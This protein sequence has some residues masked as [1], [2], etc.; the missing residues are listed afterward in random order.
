MTQSSPRV[1]IAAVSPQQ[2][3]PANVGRSTAVPERTAALAAGMCAGMPDH[4]FGAAALHW[5]RDTR[6]VPK[7]G[8]LL[9]LYAVD[10]ANAEN[11]RLPRGANRLRRMVRC[12]LLET[13][14]PSGLEAARGVLIE[15]M[16]VRLADYGLLLDDLEPGKP[17]AFCD[18]QEA[19]LSLEQK[20]PHS[21]DT[22]PR[23]HA[24]VIGRRL[25]GDRLVD[26]SIA[27][28]EAGKWTDTKRA[29]LCGINRSEFSGTWARRYN[30]IMGHMAEWQSM[31]MSYIYRAQMD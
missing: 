15:R 9:Y 20:P 14:D 12:A 18:G 21:R 23:V 16:M 24:M 27:G 2:T 3:D 7:L 6:Y 26:L 1:A 8:E 4:H 11:W 25:V 22:L 10:L 17:Y 19:I 28:T 30:A 29:I 5:G 31:A 13:A